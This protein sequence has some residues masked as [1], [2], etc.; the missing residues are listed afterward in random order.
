[1][2]FPPPL[3]VRARDVLPA[4]VAIGAVCARGGRERGALLRGGPA[5]HA[6]GIPGILAPLR[7]PELQ[8][9]LLQHQ[10]ELGHIDCYFSPD[11]DARKR[12][13]T[14]FSN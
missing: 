3:Q 6:A 8:G 10:G 12:A 5:P 14:V 13:H 2:L 9:G 1:M 7:E 4:L 11:R